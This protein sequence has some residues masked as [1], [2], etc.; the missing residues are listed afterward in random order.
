MSMA[1]PATKVSPVSPWSVAGRT[2]RGFD[3]KLKALPAL[4]RSAGPVAA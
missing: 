4:A 1:T 2:R 3:E